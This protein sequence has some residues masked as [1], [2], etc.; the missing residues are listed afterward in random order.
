MLLILADLHTELLLSMLQF[1]LVFVVDL[2]HCRELVVEVGSVKTSELASKTRF[3]DLSGDK[4][5]GGRRRK[6]EESPPQATVVAVAGADF[7][8]GLIIPAYPAENKHTHS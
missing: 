2:V 3:R 8:N 5:P 7:T 4:K 6:R 1:F